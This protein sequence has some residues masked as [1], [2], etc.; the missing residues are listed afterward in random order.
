MRGVSPSF[1]THNTGFFFSFLE[2]GEPQRLGDECATC[3]AGESREGRTHARDDRRCDGIRV[4][5]M[6]IPLPLRFLLCRAPPNSHIA[7]FSSPVVLPVAHASFFFFPFS[8]NFLPRSAADLSCPCS[9]LVS[10][11]F[12]PLRLAP[13]TLAQ[14]PASRRRPS[15]S[16]SPRSS[17][18]ARVPRPS[19]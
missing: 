12:A 17:R 16:P 2:G 9:R 11:R 15:R 3:V 8:P 19:K 18:P 4:F 5:A 13:L 1:S 14:P 7:F 10:S 6:G